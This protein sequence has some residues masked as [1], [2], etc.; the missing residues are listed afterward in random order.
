MIEASAQQHGGAII[1]TQ[2]V[3]RDGNKDKEGYQRDDSNVWRQRQAL[4]KK[5][6]N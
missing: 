1:W 4:N 2:F 3:P 6:P 5:I